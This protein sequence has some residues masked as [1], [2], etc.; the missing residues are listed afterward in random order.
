M[1]IRAWN[2]QSGSSTDKGQVCAGL[3]LTFTA[4]AQLS[5]RPRIFTSHV[6]LLAFDVSSQFRLQ[7]PVR[8]AL[9]Y[10]CIELYIVGATTAPV[11]FQKGVVAL[12]AP[13]DLHISYHSLLQS[14]SPGACFETWA[15][16]PT[17]RK[18]SNL[19]KW[20]LSI[21]W[22]LNGYSAV[23]KNVRYWLFKCQ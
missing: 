19:K 12:Q 18:A 9:R 3:C 21:S 7:P 4:M 13:F 10:A 22:K 6:I 11:T 23:V 15:L 17:F 5:C 20:K 2:S 14:W 8:G 1:N 16:P